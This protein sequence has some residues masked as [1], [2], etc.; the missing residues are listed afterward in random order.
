VTESLPILWHYTP[1][2]AAALVHKGIKGILD[3]GVINVSTHDVPR[4]ERPVVWF[5]ADQEFEATAVEVAISTKLGTT[6]HAT[7]IDD[8]V[9]MGAGLFRFGLPEARLQPYVK[10]WR[11][12]AITSERRQ[13]LSRAARRV[14]ADPRD[15]WV[16]FDPISLEDA[17]L[18]FEYR[19]DGA[20]K[21]A[22][23]TQMRSVVAACAKALMPE[24]ERRI[25]LISRF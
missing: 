11:E 15:W 1:G 12:M 22:P 5:S 23:I 25:R 13:R 4:R 18:Q 2:V 20:W 17:E 16:S 10:S 24:Y 14:K 7:T 8:H 19:S 3:S 9:V 6:F 21:A